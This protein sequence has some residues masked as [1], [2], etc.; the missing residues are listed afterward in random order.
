MVVDVVVVTV[1]P[2][3]IV[4]L[5]VVVLD[6]TGLLVGSTSVGAKVAGLI[7]GLEV[8]LIGLLVGDTV[9]PELQPAVLDTSPTT[10]SDQ[11]PL[12]SCCATQKNAPPLQENSPPL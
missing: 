6:C 10:A 9:T 7:I 11:P 2:V 8:T 12:L 1:A 4:V 3:L 5:D